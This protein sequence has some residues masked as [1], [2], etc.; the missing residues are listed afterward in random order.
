MCVCVHIS[1]NTEKCTYMYIYIY[2]CISPNLLS[3]ETHKLKIQCSYW[4]VQNLEISDPPRNE[5]KSVIATRLPTACYII[6]LLNV[7]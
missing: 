7:L 5:E 6:L 2:I 4:N 1:P 3:Y